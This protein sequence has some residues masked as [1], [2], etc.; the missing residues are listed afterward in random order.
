MQFLVQLNLLSTF[1][2]NMTKVQTNILWFFTFMMNLNS[3]DFEIL[4]LK[5]LNFGNF[6][7]TNSVWNH[8]KSGNLN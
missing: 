3:F 1:K 8:L 5:I 4:K 6:G 7:F 2:Q